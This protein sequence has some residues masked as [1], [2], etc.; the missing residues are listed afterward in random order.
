MSLNLF[1]KKFTCFFLFALMLSLLSLGCGSMPWEKRTTI[2]YQVAGET[3]TASKATLQTLCASG[4]LGIEDCKAARE[5]Y[6]QAVTIYHNMEA[7]AITAIDSGD[8]S[9]YEELN[10]QLQILLATISGFLVTQ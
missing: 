4:E 3:L 5:A 8:S 9:T 1:N 6:N 2:T 7:A 10:T